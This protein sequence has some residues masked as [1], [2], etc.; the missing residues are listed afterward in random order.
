VSSRQTTESTGLGDTILT[1]NNGLSWTH[2]WNSRFRTQLLG[3]LRNDKYQGAGVSRVD[4]TTSAGVRV[5]Y[6]F[7]R[8]LRFGVEALRT[9]RDSDIDAFDYRRNLILFTVGATL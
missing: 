7:R 5:I 6:R 1:R 3:T 2:D 8:W 4:D 9:H